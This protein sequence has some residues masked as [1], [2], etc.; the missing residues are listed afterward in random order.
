MDLEVGKQRSHAKASEEYVTV[1]FFYENGKAIQW[2]VPIEYRRTGT[3]FGESKEEEIL[4]Y[5]SKVGKDCHPKT[6]PAWRKKQNEFWATKP[7]AAV[8]KTFFDVLASDF[9]WK[10]IQSDFPSNS[11]PARRIQELKEFGYTLA[12]DTKRKDRKTGTKCTHHQ[13]LPLARGGIT[14]YEVWSA[15]TRE[16]IIK[17]LNSY[18]AYEGKLGTREG[19][20]PDHKFPEIR[21]DLTTRRENLETIEDQ[22]VLEDFQLM[23]NQRNQQKR[24]VCRNC[25][26]TGVRGFP[27]GIK[28]FYSGDGNWPADVP[29]RGEDARAGCIGCGWYDLET[30]RKSLNDSISEGEV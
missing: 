28:Y 4:D 25:S 30:W 21:W 9:T 12:T 13:L 6:W 29:R 24:E 2:D 22:T 11:N 15:E 10:S 16:R 7:R 1:D 23:T 27:F 20:L 19:L 14:G 17:L 8:T 26:A 18:D 3:H 5:V